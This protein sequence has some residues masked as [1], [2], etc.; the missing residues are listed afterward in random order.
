MRPVAHPR[1]KPVLHGIEVD[2]VDVVLEIALIANRMLPEAPL[3]E[4]VLSVRMARDADARTR[5]RGGEAALLIR[6]SRPEKFEVI[7]WQG[8]HEMQMLRQHH[9]RIDH[10]R[11]RLA[12]LADRGAQRLHVVDQCARIPI[13][14]RHREEVCSTGNEIAPISNDAARRSD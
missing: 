14:K 7:R 9:D 6:L 1:D 10:E 8:H 4:R 3:P 13:F 12:C 5:D 2:I 11:V